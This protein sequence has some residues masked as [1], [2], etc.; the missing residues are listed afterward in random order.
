MKLIDQHTYYGPNLY[1]PVSVIRLMVEPG[2]L[3]LANKT[4]VELESG[5]LDRI[6]EAV[7]ELEPGPEHTFLWVLARLA[8]HLQQQ[9]GAVPEFVEVVPG[10]ETNQSEILLG[11]QHPQITQEAWNLAGM[12]AFHSLQDGTASDTGFDYSYLYSDFVR[13][14]KSLILDPSTWAMIR[15]CE[16]RDIPWFRISKHS[17]QIQLGEGCHQHR[18]QGAITSGTSQL[19]FS[20]A[21]NKLAAFDLLRTLGLPVPAFRMV[22]DREDAV[23]AAEKLGYPLVLSTMAGDAVQL[24]QAGI[25]CANTLLCTMEDI[26]SDGNPLLL[27]SDVPGNNYRLLVVNR[28]LITAT[29]YIPPTVTDNGDN[30]TTQVVT[31]DVT[32]HVHPEN[33]ALAETVARAIGL[34]VADI[35]FITSDISKSWREVGGVV[36]NINPAPELEPYLANGIV[37]EQIVSPIIDMLFPSS[38]KVRI[39]TVA[40]TG[41]NG[42]TTTCYMLSS[43]LEHVGLSVGLSCSNGVYMNGDLMRPEESSYG[44]KARELLLD[45]RIESGVFELA[46]GGVSKYGCFINNVDV[47]AVINLTSDHVGELGTENFDK[48][49]ATKKMVAKLARKVLVLN[50]DDPVVLGFRHESRAKAVVLVSLQSDNPEVMKHLAAGGTAFCLREEGKSLPVF[51][52]HGEKEQRLMDLTKVPA[53]FNGTARHNI[54]NSLFAI[55]TADSMGINTDCIRDTLYQFAMSWDMT[56]GRLNFFPG[57]PFQVI[58]DYAHNPDGFSKI[59]Q[60]LNQNAVPGKRTLILASTRRMESI[61]ITIGKMAS[62]YFDLIICC[63]TKEGEGKSLSQLLDNHVNGL[64]EAGVPQNQ[65]LKIHDHT[66]ALEHAMQRAEPGDQ[67]LILHKRHRKEIIWRKIEAVAK[68]LT[69]D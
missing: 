37:P 50:A 52:Q 9:P 24:I 45:P 31:K 42:K 17:S 54:Q 16:Q 10:A 34:E 62:E 66:D 35:T 59:L 40:V 69:G 41:T 5:F 32:E 19:A 36:C 30:T 6:M 56:P 21:Q 49:V 3:E 53:T 64:I 28:H 63:A 33:R 51:K 22:I 61:S 27:E 68:N 25:D 1:A 46:R 43:I 39:P 18:L 26:Q 58:L 13:K 47:A 23:P 29:Q 2:P 14:T 48:L 67:I 4:L 65:I 38:A 55:A 57:L 7:P 20:L 8:N 60:F 44:R 12:L 15:V 11:F